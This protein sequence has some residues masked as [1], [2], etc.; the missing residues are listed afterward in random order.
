MTSPLLARAVKLAS[1]TTVV[2]IGRGVLADAP[3]H[4]ADLGTPLLLVAD[5]T[6]W[7][8][9]GERLAALLVDAGL[10]TVEP[11]IFPGL[12]SLHPTRET[13]DVVRAALEATG[14]FAVAVGSGSLN[15]VV[16]RASFEVERPYAVVATAASMDGYTGFGAP[17]TIGGLKVT[18]P[19][20]APRIAIL[21]LD[22]M[23]AAPAPM[24]ASGYGDLLA[25]L[26]GGAD[27]I[28]A[29]AAGVEPI[30]QVAWELVQDGVREALARPDALAAGDAGAY[31]GLVEGLCLS[32][33]AM[34]VYEGTRPASGAEH[35]FSH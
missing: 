20:P 17:I 24:V 18:M 7:A 25:K 1:D 14:A 6:T 29:D 10:R 15:D 13:C 31:E 4:L 19:C 3:H 34:Q 11:L 28:F 33:L 8:A 9:A 12:P 27:W 26:P 5:E 22:V 35:Y 2:D 32:G 16:K 23:A 30:D 21:D